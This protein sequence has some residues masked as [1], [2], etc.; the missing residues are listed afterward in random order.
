MM[1]SNESP[2]QHVL[3]NKNMFLMRFSKEFD[4]GFEYSQHTDIKYKCIYF[5]GNKIKY[6]RTNK[7]MCMYI[8]PIFMY[9]NGR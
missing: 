2:V 8:Q 6:Y 9:I 1:C 4:F 3:T 5:K 7:Y